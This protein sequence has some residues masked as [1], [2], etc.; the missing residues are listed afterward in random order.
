MSDVPWSVGGEEIRDISHLEWCV[1]PRHG[2][3]SEVDVIFGQTASWRSRV[4]RFRS[5]FFVQNSQADNRGSDPPC[6]SLRC[7]AICCGVLSSLRQ[8]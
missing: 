1:G 7:V 2:N 4:E 6:P 3:D 8:D 5:R